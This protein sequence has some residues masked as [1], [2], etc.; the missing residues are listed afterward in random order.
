[1][2]TFFSLFLVSC[3]NSN[4]IIGSAQYIEHGNP[5][6]YEGDDKYGVVYINL[7]DQYIIGDVESYKIE[8]IDI[9]NSSSINTAEDFNFE[10][11]LLCIPLNNSGVSIGD[12]LV[13]KH[14][15]KVI[16]NLEVVTT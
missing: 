15:H 6:L 8:D 7:E 13:L 16:G 11:S 1:M 4:E 9:E 5:Q 10:N 14:N 12:T 3:N 2:I